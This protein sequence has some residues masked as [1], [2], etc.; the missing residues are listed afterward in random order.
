[1][2]IRVEVDET[3][4]AALGLPIATVAQVLSEENINASG[5][6]LRDRNAEYIV[7]TLSRF[8]DLADIENVTVT[9]IDGKAVAKPVSTGLAYQEYVSVSGDLKMGDV[10]IVRG[11]ERL[12]DGQAVSIIRKLE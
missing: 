11:N 8:E 2:V 12:Q 9:V 4:L 5:G 1:M 10:A 7:R 6:R 3:K